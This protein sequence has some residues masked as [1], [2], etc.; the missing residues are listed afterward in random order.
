MATKT[1]KT[2]ID[3]ET[4]IEAQYVKVANPIVLGMQ[5]GLGIFLTAILLPLAIWLLLT[6]MG[7]M[8]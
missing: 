3:K 6:L 8:S 7:R 5:I 1:K 2:F 4:G